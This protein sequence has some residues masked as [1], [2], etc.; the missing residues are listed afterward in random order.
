MI[1]KHLQSQEHHRSS[2]AYRQNEGLPEN[3]KKTKSIKND[4]RTTEFNRKT[5]S[6]N[7]RFPLKAQ[8]ME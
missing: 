4:G 3:Q 2:G 7:K 1:K 5:D 8:K 6:V